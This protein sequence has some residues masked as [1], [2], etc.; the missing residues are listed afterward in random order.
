MNLN[1]RILV[2]DDNRAIHADF[3]KI[4]GAPDEADVA[5]DAAEARLFGAAQGVWFEID[6]ASQGQEGVEKVAQSL[7]ENRPY[8]MAFVDYRMPPGWDGIETTK[9]LWT[10]CPDLQVVICTA[11]AD[12]PWEEVLE[13]LNAQDRLLI[14]KKPFDAIEVMQLARA[15]TEKWRLREE[16]RARVDNLQHLVTARTQELEKS[17]AAAVQ[18]MQEAVAAREKTEQTLVELN[19][20]VAERKRSRRS[21]CKRKKWTPL[22][23]W[24]VA[25]RTISTTSSA[26]SWATRKSP[27]WIPCSAPPQQSVWIRF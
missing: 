18:T 11:F 3:R 13:E 17:R 12:C 27:N 20:E 24:P 9:Q 16:S 23:V 10:V 1:R 19:H 25:S 5:L 7:A 4:L 8:S 15:L 21:S 26:R 14:L 2:I 6:T 22:V